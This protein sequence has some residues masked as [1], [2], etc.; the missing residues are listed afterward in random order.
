[1]TF[2]RGHRKLSGAFLLASR[3]GAEFDARRVWE[4]VVG[5]YKFGDE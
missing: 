2:H 4:K 3:L 1:M 5:G